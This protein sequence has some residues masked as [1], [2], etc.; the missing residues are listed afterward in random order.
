MN[1]RDLF[2]L[3]FTVCLWYI[4]VDIIQIGTLLFFCKSMISLCL[5]L[6]LI[7][8]KEYGNKTIHD[9]VQVETTS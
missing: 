4:L 5:I 3:I 8:K 7:D 1:V 6:C 9:N 2:I